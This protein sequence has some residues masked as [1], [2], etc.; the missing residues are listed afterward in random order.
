M[1]SGRPPYSQASSLYDRIAP[2]RAF[3]LRR[4]DALRL[5]SEEHQEIINAI[6]AGDGD[7]AFRLLVDHVS[8]E[9]ELFADLLSALHLRERQ[10]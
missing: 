9:N 4:G 10:I 2:Y 5:A 3:Q 7:K 8:L 6:V 1:S